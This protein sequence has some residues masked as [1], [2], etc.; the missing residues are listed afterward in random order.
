MEN[1]E[2]AYTIGEV[3]MMILAAAL[4]GAKGPVLVKLGLGAALDAWAKH[5]EKK[6]AK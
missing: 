2:L 3:V 1:V 5:K 6:A 4:A